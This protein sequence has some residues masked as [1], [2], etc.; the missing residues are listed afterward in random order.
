MKT[1]LQ[2]VVSV[3]L[4]V[5]QVSGKGFQRVYS[6]DGNDVWAVGDSGNVFRSFDGGATWGT[7][8]LG[9]SI[10]RSVT[11]RNT[12][13]WIVG[14][15]GVCYRSTN[16]GESFGLQTLAL[17]SSLLTVA[18]ASDLVGWIGG[19]AGT[20][21]KTTDGGTTWTAL[22][23]PTL[24]NI[25]CLRFSSTSNGW[26]VGGAGIVMRTTN[27]GTSWSSLSVGTVTRD[28][29]SVDVN[30]SAIYVVGAQGTAAK[31]TDNGSTWSIL[32]FNMES[33][34]DI[35]DVVVLS[36]ATAYFCGGGGFIRKTIDG[37]A[38]YTF[39]LHPMLA[40][41]N[42]L[43]FF[44]ANKGWA[45]S[46]KNSAVLRTTDG[47]STWLLP[48]GTTVSY[49]WIQK[50]TGSSIGNSF[51]INPLNR[52]RMYAILGSTVYM[53]ADR[54]ETWSSTSATPGGSTWSFYI[55][56]KDTNLWV[57]ANSSGGKSVKRSTNRGSTWTSVLTRNFTTYGM[58]LEMDPD[59]PDTLLFGAEGT[60]SGP[61]GILYRS[62]NFGATW[63]TLA[64]TNFRS[65]CDLLIVPDSTNIVYVGDGVTSSGSAQFWRSTNGGLNWTSIY[66]S[67]S[68]EIP[69]I[70]VSRHRKSDVYATAW[71]SQAFVKSANYG[72]SFS[73]IMPTS[74]T[75]G[76]DIAK[77][78]PNVVM[79][80]VYGGSTSY[81]STNAGA[82]FI[83]T[84]LTGSNSAVLA[85]DR[86][87]FLV[88]Q[89]SNGIW[90]YT[91]TYA[92]P[93]NN[94]QTLTLLAPAGGEVWQG[95]STYAVRWNAINI[96]NVK[97]EYKT[98]PSGTWQL[99]TSST[100]A[101]SGS[102]LWTCPPVASTQARVR[103]SD[104]LDSTPLDSNVTYFTLD[105]PLPIQLTSFTGHALNGNVVLDWATA[106]EINNYGFEVQRRLA[107][108]SDFAT[109][110]G[111]FVP[112]HGTTNTPQVYQFVDTDPRPS[113]FYRLKQ[114]DLD[115]ST[116]FSEPVF[117]SVMTSVQNNGAPRTFLVHQNY[118][119][120]FNP[121]TMLEYEIP[122]AGRVHVEVFNTLGERI[123]VV[124]DKVQ[125]AGKYRVTFDANGI[126]SGVYFY[127]I[128][129]GASTATGRMIL[130]R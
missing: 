126:P 18:F 16:N 4:V 116:W 119:N 8:P 63:D 123:A 66:T 59:H 10:L 57:I 22:P 122:S 9:S 129:A 89:A 26:L 100:P 78:D 85:Y 101:T 75:W 30:G 82:S 44:D 72:A 51:V 23:S 84:S 70:A 92:V 99:I 112:G 67:P 120:P 97:L 40:D 128:T 102:Y 118:P 74:S 34:S 68:S 76:V 107:D 54:G 36:P 96:P 25:Y 33:K 79:Y 69:M 105:P 125:E 35:N 19:N 91:I 95:G 48:T 90:K 94:A 103:V 93:T 64:R 39:Q 6:L 21:L 52:D 32:N 17:G 43:F 110:P 108:S 12:S 58:P 2:V 117:V 87:T 45:C 106:S 41:L 3:L 49:S 14:D 27:G 28:L 7:Y 62:T 86:G 73:Q 53:S 38:S 65:P 98:S 56:P 113:A 37:A 130:M 46:R 115:G 88:H 109:L 111:G 24:Q 42:D 47:G 127:R 83:S 13:I 15:G 55:S 1:T 60:S 80:G 104:A 31:S 71:S 114:I 124:V 50:A 61:D 81:L 11:A 77:D 121:S 5:M 20:L 29:F